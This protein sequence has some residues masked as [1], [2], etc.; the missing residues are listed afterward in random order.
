MLEFTFSEVKMS[1]I[2]TMLREIGKNIKHV[3]I[4]KIFLLMFICYH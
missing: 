4:S 2:K 3:P 1:E